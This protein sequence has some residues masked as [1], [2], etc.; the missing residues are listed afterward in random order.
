MVRLNLLLASVLLASS[1]YGDELDDEL[2][3]FD[4]ISQNSV[5]VNLSL[6]EEPPKESPIKV[7]GYLSFL[8]AYNYAQSSSSVV[9]PGDTAMDFR[10]LSRSRI[11]AGMDL[12]GKLGD[13]FKAK[14]ELM[15]WYDAAWALNGI[16][17]YTQAFLD[18]YESFYDIKDAYIQGSL[19]SNLD[20]KVGRQIVIWGKSDSL[21]I[22]D[23]INPLDNREP[24]MTDIEDLRLTETM[25]KLDYY[26]GDWSA[27][28]IA[29]FEPR[30]QIEPAFG[31]D[32]RPADIFG[33][34]LPS[35]NF[36]EVKS[37]ECNSDNFQ[38]ASSLDGHFSGWDLSLYAAHVL[39]D[40]FGIEKTATSTY[41]T[42]SLV[43]MGGLAANVASGSL[44]YKTEIAYIAGID[45]RGTA[46]KDRFDMLVGVDYSGI[47][48]TLI[49]LEVANRHIIDY[50]SSMLTLSLQQ[51]AAS[52][53][54]PDFVR[55]DSVQIAFRSSY[56]FDNDNA[57]MSYL[58]MLFG[59]SNEYG[60]FDGANFDGG[61]QRLWLSY[62]YND[63]VT[64]E[65]G[66]VD[67]FEGDNQ[68]IPFYSAIQNN[69]RIFAQVE[70]KF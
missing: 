48:N 69:D 35:S 9:A 65:A 57:T 46:K 7:G 50:E 45:Y 34:P 60:N 28:F 6:P 44:L 41:R 27:S 19:S 16:D 4:E 14:L 66:I 20:I 52:G 11:K 31:S 54:F 25:A 59:G 18:S 64:M 10:G 15:A 38:Y 12:N 40:R 55:E 29:I 37:L 30:V 68:A 26:F 70:Y 13:N 39:S 22:T 1:L 24:G 53:T 61:L 47:K 21:R 51:A 56:T 67:Y 49:S 17:N 23:V 63:S 58:G 62:K 5:D 32:Y 8:A 42:Y 2:N 36:P 3:A 43:D 33:T